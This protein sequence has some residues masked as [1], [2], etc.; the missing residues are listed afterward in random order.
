LEPSEDN[1]FS[2]MEEVKDSH[3]PLELIKKMAEEEEK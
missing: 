2:L 1:E 3:N